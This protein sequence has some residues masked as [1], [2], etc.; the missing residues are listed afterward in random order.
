MRFVTRCLIEHSDS[1]VLFSFLF[2]NFF[3]DYHRLFKIIL[4]RI[5][6]SRLSNQY[7]IIFSSLFNFHFQNLKNYF[8][9][10]TSWLINQEVKSSL[11]SRNG[12]TIMI[13]WKRISTMNIIY[14]IFCSSINRSKCWKID[15][16]WFHLV[17][18]CGEMDRDSIGIAK[19]AQWEC[20]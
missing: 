14:N 18:R 11:S 4:D 16:D 5:R 13:I 6:S 17:R 2:I 7:P 8:I 12:I 20:K 9:W 3:A 10:E 15:L 19:I 1:F